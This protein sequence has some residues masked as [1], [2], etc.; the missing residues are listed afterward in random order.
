MISCVF[1]LNHFVYHNIFCSDKMPWRLSLSP[2]MLRSN[3]VLKKEDTK[4]FSTFE[5]IPNILYEHNQLINFRKYAYHLESV[6]L[7]SQKSRV[8]FDVDDKTS[9]WSEV[10]D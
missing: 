10:S 5:Y 8:H 3:S 2:L 4:Y 6:Y 7:L 1:D 9:T